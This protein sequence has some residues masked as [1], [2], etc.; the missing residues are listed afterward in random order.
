[1]SM[2]A[3]TLV[4]D[5]I[6]AYRGGH[7]LEARQLL[8]HAT[9]VNQMH[10]QAWMW[11]SAVVESV[12]DQRTCLENV[13]YINPHNE[14]ARR[15][16][17]ILES[18]AP[19]SRAVGG[20]PNLDAVRQKRSE[21][22]AKTSA[23]DEELSGDLFS[24]PETSSPS[25]TRDP[26]GEPSPSEYDDWVAGLN[27]NVNDAPSPSS[28]SPFTETQ[29]M[30]QDDTYSQ[31]FADAFDDPFDDDDFDED[32]FNQAI[33][34]ASSDGEV[35]ADQTL[36]ARFGQMA[37]DDLGDPFGDD[38]F[39]DEAFG[40]ADDEGDDDLLKGP[41]S[42]AAF[43]AELPPPDIAPARRKQDSRRASRAERRSPREDE[44]YSGFFADDDSSTV[45]DL[46]PSEYFRAI[47]RNI[48]ATRLPG[49]NERY[50]ALALLGLF[51]L[52]ALNLG[53]VALLVAQLTG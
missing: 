4:R 6:R 20:G 41:F 26:G 25:A 35:D 34:A 47:P 28:V 23:F 50:P 11:L 37:A 3:D 17:K 21:P 53:A 42:S 32:T 39:G 51:L 36:E 43:D 8:E 45:S 15:G 40:A 22:P 29:E 46:D 38:D 16:L 24:P 31:L 52:I 44:A 13:L 30:M 9:E 14:N 12:E 19:E 49:T 48:K 7:K 5:A 2:D 33:P 18:K 10:E 27:I 1:M